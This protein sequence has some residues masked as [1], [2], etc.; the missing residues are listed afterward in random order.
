M[1]L[2]SSNSSQNIFSQYCMNMIID[3]RVAYVN[4]K[5]IGTLDKH[6]KPVF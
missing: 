1:F 6:I 5:M 3:I 4:V 2:K